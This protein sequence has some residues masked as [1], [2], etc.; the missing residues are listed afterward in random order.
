M[1]CVFVAHGKEGNLPVYRVLAV[2]A[3]RVVDRRVGR[4]VRVDFKSRPEQ[5]MCTSLA[6]FEAFCVALLQ[7]AFVGTTPI[8]FV[9]KT[10]LI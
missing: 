9:R 2:H 8:L 10:E 3:P 4:R 6:C 1:F 7:A 5:E